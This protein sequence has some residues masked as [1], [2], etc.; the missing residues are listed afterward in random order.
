MMQERKVTA[1]VA[2]PMFFQVLKNK[3]ESEIRSK[4]KLAQVWFDTS[5]KLAQSI[6]SEKIRRLMFVPILRK[7]GGKLRIILSGGAP[8]DP[9]VEQFFNLIGINLL[10]GYG[11]T[12]TSPTISVNVPHAQRGGSVGKPLRGV[13]VRIDAKDGELE[14]EILTRGPH[15]MKGYY[16][17]DDLTKTTVDEEGW[18]RTGDLGHLD[19][20]GYL[21]ITG[22]AKNLI[23][24]SNGLQVQTE[25][26]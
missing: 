24:L 19:E 20:D 5:I 12:E 3:I 15:V 13:E 23:V 11:L 1:M 26:V 6:Q 7:F 18:L 16:K 14:G 10:Q 17:L 8:L 4:G 25:E 22:R 2:V 21:Y 9:Q